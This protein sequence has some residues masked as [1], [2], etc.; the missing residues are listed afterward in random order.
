MKEGEYS[1]FLNWYSFIQ[2][3][4]S[5][6][7]P[8]DPSND[9]KAGGLKKSRLSRPASALKPIPVTTSKNTRKCIINI[10]NNRLFNRYEKLRKS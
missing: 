5:L 1:Y 4:K 7:E 6:I 10:L 8:N 9:I 2:T 3:N